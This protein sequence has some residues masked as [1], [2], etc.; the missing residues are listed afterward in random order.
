[1]FSVGTKLYSSSPALTP[2]QFKNKSGLSSRHK[3]A[4]FNLL[5][6]FYIQPNGVNQKATTSKASMLI[7]VDFSNWKSW[8]FFT[9]SGTR[10]WLRN[11]DS[12]V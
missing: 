9:S 8:F 6:H 5:I 11:K 10:D 2:G 3:L 7:F 4:E 1:V 12:S